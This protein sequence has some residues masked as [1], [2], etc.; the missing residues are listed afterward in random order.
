MVSMAVWKQSEPIRG[1]NR[2]D[3]I[4][5]RSVIA[6]PLTRESKVSF[7]HHQQCFT[8][9]RLGVGDMR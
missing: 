9:I 8:R 2:V 4:H 5:I 6:S 7:G 1:Q 3:F